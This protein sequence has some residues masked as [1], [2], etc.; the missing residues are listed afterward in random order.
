[1]SLYVCTVAQCFVVQIRSAA[2]RVR[3]LVSARRLLLSRDSVDG[4]G[5]VLGQ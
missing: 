3:E 2:V 1:M 4:K 5:D